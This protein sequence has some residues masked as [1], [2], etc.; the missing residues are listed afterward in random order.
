MELLMLQFV[1]M[2][3]ADNTIHAK[4]KSSGL[5]YNSRTRCL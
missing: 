3:G 5:F 4:G 2:S 1:I